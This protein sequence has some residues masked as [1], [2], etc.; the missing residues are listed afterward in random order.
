MV[1]IFDTYIYIWKKFKDF[2]IESSFWYKLS[3]TVMGVQIY[4]SNFSILH[5]EVLSYVNKYFKSNF[6]YVLFKRTNEKPSKDIL[7]SYELSL[8][9]LK[10]TTLSVWSS[11][12]H[13]YLCFIDLHSFSLSRSA[14]DDIIHSH[15]H[16]SCFGGRN[17]CLLFN[18]EA[19]LQF[20]SD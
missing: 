3:V 15:D 20:F 6:K 11:R 7:F 19:F 12:P 9:E 1:F 5:S 16:F 8:V 17:E 2:L 4:E 14:S 18:S 10:M 13:N